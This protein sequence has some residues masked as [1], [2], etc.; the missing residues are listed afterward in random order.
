MG[1]KTYLRC[2]FRNAFDIFQFIVGK[3]VLWDCG[4][5]RKD[6]KFYWGD[7]TSQDD[8][9]EKF[10]NL[11]RGV[12]TESVGTVI[13]IL[14]RQKAILA[15]NKIYLDLFT[16]AEQ[17]ELRDIDK[18]FNDNIR[19]LSD[20]TF[21][22]KNYLLP[23]NHFEASVF[24]YKHA[25]KEAETL[26]R[27]KGKTIMD[28]GGFIGDSVLIFEEL[29]PDKIYT[30]EASPENF[31][32]LK[33]TLKLNGLKNVV[34]ENFALGAEKGECT[35]KGTG[36]GTSI[37]KGSSGSNQNEVRVPVRTL[38]D[39]VSEHKIKNIG[40]I[41]VDIEG[42]EPMFLAGAKKTICEQ[43]PILLLSIYHNAH[44]FFELKP[45]IESWDLGY[46]FKIYRPI[47]GGSTGETLLIA[48]IV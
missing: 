37:V 32:L 19:R 38:D 27:V 7:V 21:A 28:I 10:L 34:A 43:K 42:A 1:L 8:F 35:L 9:A 23:S 30:F 48:E 25:R 44:D 26:N 22:Y 46:K 16:T 20:G 47:L 36:S 39:Y 5:E 40:L 33:K 45:L 17:Q 18:N 41:K 2:Y 11:T 14:S 13:R 15:S 4:G 29:A 24:Y 31:E 12:D 3:K 6:I